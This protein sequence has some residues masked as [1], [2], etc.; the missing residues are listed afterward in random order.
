MIFEEIKN[1]NNRRKFKKSF[2]FYEKIFPKQ[3]FEKILNIFM[4]D[5]K[6][7]EI[8]LFGIYNFRI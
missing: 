5:T 8:A 3:Q 2:R 6:E 7:F 4:C 1:I